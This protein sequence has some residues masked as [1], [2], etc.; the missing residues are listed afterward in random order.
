[1]I[2]H[3]KIFQPYSKKLQPSCDNIADRLYGRGHQR[4]AHG[5]QVARG[6]VIKITLA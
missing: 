3:Q 1:M 2:T 4:D 5:H 6:P